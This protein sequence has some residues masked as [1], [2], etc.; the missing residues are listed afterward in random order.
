MPSRSG[1]SS[2]SQLRAKENLGDDISGRGYFRRGIAKRD[3]R[4]HQVIVAVVVA[5]VDKVGSEAPVEVRPIPKLGDGRRMDGTLTNTMKGHLPD[6]YFDVLETLDLHV[7][8][9]VHGGGDGGNNR[10]Q[11]FVLLC[12]L[13]EEKHEDYQMVN[14]LEDQVQQIK[15]VSGKAYQ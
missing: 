9:G 11:G 13:Y 7:A 6:T 12:Q 1:T 8:T 2:V 14:T 3:E 5:C 4:L 15:I 10:P